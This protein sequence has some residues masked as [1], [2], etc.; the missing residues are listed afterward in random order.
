M[1]SDTAQY[2]YSRHLKN[3]PKRHEKHFFSTE[4]CFRAEKIFSK[5]DCELLLYA[6]LTKLICILC[7]TKKVSFFSSKPIFNQVRLVKR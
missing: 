5:I 3:G 7:W 6:N 1:F 4:C 2:F